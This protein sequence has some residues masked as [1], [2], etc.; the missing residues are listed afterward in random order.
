MYVQAACALP[1]ISHKV[2]GRTDS[3][4]GSGGTLSPVTLCTTLSEL[5]VPELQQQNPCLHHSLSLQ[6]LIASVSPFWDSRSYFSLLLH[7]IF[8]CLCY[9]GFRAIGHVFSLDVAIPNERG[10]KASSANPIVDLVSFKIFSF[11]LCP[12][13]VLT[14]PLLLWFRI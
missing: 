7:P 5:S 9:F 10:K 4:Q 13:P 6:R 12:H 2:A 3:S 11:F 8:L 1:C 14:W